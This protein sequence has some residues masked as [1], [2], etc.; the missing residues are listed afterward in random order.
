MNVFDHLF[1]I[2]KHEGC[3]HPLAIV[4]DATLDNAMQLS[5]QTS[6]NTLT[7]NVQSYLSGT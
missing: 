2:D 1:T 6:V 4:N 3:F 5:V 7:N